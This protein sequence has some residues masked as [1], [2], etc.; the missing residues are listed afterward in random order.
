MPPGKDKLQ[1][2]AVPRTSGEQR[3]Q[4]EYNDGPRRLFAPSVSVTGDRHLKTGLLADL[5]SR[6]R[7]LKNETYA[8]YLAARDPR[9]PWYAK[10][11]I[12]LVVAYALSPIDLIPDFVP[13]LGYVDD[14][15][16]IPAGVALALKLI[17]REVME[18]ARR[19][20]SEMVI[21]KRTG[22]LGAIII[23][24]IWILAIILCGLLIRRLLRKPV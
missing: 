20:A 22:R 6:A 19:Q 9:T 13:V 14:L 2:P 23:V 24:L 1:N 5:K 3:S 21:D 7:A 8:L 16:I 17:P 4:V 10:G 12:L 11:L 15:V 18:E